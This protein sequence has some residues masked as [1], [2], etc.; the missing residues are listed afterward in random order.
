MADDCEISSFLLKF[1]QL[2]YA[3]NK[4]CL[5]LDCENGETLVQL[6]VLLKSDQ[7]HLRR[8]TPAHHVGPQ[9]RRRH[10]HDRHPQFHPPPPRVREQPARWRRREKRAL[11]RAMELNNISRLPPA[12]RQAAAALQSSAV[13]AGPPPLRS[14]AVKAGP[15]PLRSTAVE[16]GPLPLMSAAVEAVPL[17]LKSA[18]FEAGLPL[19]QQSA[20]VE[21]VPPPPKSTAVEADLPLPQQSAAV[22]AAIPPLHSYAELVIVADPLKVIHTNNPRPVPDEIPLLP[23]PT[24]SWPGHYLPEDLQH[25][26]P[27]LGDQGLATFPR[28]GDGGEASTL[29]PS[30]EHTPQPLEH[31]QGSGT[32]ELCWIWE[33]EGSKKKKRGGRKKK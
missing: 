15:S 11:D 9:V 7:Q 28:Y 12:A 1:H 10:G 18:T 33:T 29:P 2:K 23:L 27:S 6:Q 26:S 14:V 24:L 19:P 32:P 22:E 8:H 16:A 4:A 3:G 17:P 13:K 31:S 25:H 21:A 20:A 5:W 30:Q